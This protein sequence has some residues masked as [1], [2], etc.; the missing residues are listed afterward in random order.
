MYGNRRFGGVN[1][2]SSSGSLQLWLIVILAVVAFGGTCA[3]VTGTKGEATFKVRRLEVKRAS[4][5]SD[6]YLVFTNKGVFEN[7]D[8][9]V[10][11]KCNSSDVQ[12]KLEKGK[13]Y[14][15]QVHGVRFGCTSTYKNIESVEEIECPPEW[16]DKKKKKGKK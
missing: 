10:V 16:E 3:Y 5:D 11:G 15:A 2:G 13:C 6:K 14:K 1:V 4:E 8:S 9:W 12:N 7:T